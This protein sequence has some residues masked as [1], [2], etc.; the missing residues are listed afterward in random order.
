MI[1]MK[2]KTK[3]KTKSL[4]AALAMSNSLFIEAAQARVLA[5]ITSVGCSNYYLVHN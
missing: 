5:L 3:L 4:I 2:K 1:P